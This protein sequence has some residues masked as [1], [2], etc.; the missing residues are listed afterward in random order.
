MIETQRTQSH[1]TNWWWVRHA[2]T[3][4]SGRMIGQTDVDAV[5]PSP[6]DLASIA[7]ALPRHANWLISSLSRCQQTAT[8]LIAN[9]ALS[10]NSQETMPDFKEQNFGQWEGRSYDE[11]EIRHA[12]AFWNDPAQFT[13]PEG[14][15]FA[16][17]IDRVRLVIDQHTS[18]N[19]IVVVAHAGVIRAAVAIALDLTPQQA[20]RLQIDPLSITRTSCYHHP[21]TPKGAWC[22]QGVNQLLLN[23]QN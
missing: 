6:K 8:A 7:A 23:E 20:L 5:L 2:P 16:Q 11:P 15:S 13:P 12:K 19:T 21:D 10:V 14:E 4:I 17:V 9:A 22:V 3:G 1:T 18:P